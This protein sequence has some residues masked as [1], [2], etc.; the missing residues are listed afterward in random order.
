MYNHPG[1][2]LQDKTRILRVKFRVVFE[3]V[4]EGTY[5]SKNTLD[6]IIPET[7]NWLQ[8]RAEEGDKYW[9]NALQIL[10]RRTFHNQW[11]G[12]YHQVYLRV[13][14]ISQNYLSLKHSPEN[15]KW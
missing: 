10:W 12:V 13:P 6:R 14:E 5:W 8:V 15:R 3:T 2:R 7:I 11:T 4:R 1:L 9:R